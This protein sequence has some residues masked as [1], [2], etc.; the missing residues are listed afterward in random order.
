MVVAIKL[1]KR[2]FAVP[3]GA[4]KQVVDDLMGGR[5]EMSDARDY[6]RE[7]MLQDTTRHEELGYIDFDNLNSQGRPTIIGDF[8]P[9]TLIGKRLS[10][11][12]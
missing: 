1:D 3:S 5:T 10:G 11:T 9:S 4:V 2:V 6:L 7:Q 12:F 8:Y